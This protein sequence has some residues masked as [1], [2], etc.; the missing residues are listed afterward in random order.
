MDQKK[1]FETSVA[2]AASFHKIIKY[3]ILAFA[4][5]ML[6]TAGKWDPVSADRYQSQCLQ[7]FIP[8]LLNNDPRLAD[9]FLCAAT[10]I[11]R[12]YDQMTGELMLYDHTDHERVL[13]N[14][15]SRRA[16]AR[17]NL[18]TSST[19]ASLY[20]P[21]DHRDLDTHCARHPYSSPYDKSCT[22]QC[23]PGPFRLG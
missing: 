7:L 18:N 1:H 19:L 2:R 9:D 20:E 10:L 4:A 23:I 15:Q 5:K 11:L 6:S 12:V 8:A 14:L 16:S 13:I 21:S 3:A 22:W 17:L